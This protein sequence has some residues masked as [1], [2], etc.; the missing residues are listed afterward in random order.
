MFTCS[1]SIPAGSKDGKSFC[2][3]CCFHLGNTD[4]YSGRSSTPSHISLVGVPIILNNNKKIYIYIYEKFHNWKKRQKRN[5]LEN[6]ED[7]IN[8][9]ISLKYWFPVYHFR[10]NASNT[11][12]VNATRVSFTSQQYFRT[13][14]PQCHNL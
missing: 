13:P 2:R 10:K 11:P 1:K 12:G 3:F 9:R 8:F 6:F 14:V 5:L 7:F 4:L